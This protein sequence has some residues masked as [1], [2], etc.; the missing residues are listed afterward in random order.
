MMARFRNTLLATTAMMPLGV[1]AAAANPLGSQVVGGTANVQGQGTSRVTV[2]QSTDKAIINWQ[3]FNIGTG[4]TTRF[5][6]P[7]AS[8]VTLN[9]V[10]GGLGASALDGT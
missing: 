5:V 2:T 9:R 6:Q 8:S 10:T 3:T 4:E 7:D 1:I